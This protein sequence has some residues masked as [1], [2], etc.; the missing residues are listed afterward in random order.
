MLYP[1]GARYGALK[2]PQILALKGM[3][4]ECHGKIMWD[5]VEHIFKYSS[6]ASDQD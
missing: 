5:I 4:L 6:R 2:N 3:F 1:C